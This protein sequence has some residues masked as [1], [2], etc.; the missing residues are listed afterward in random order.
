MRVVALLLTFVLAGCQGAVRD[1]RSSDDGSAIVVVRGSSC[2]LVGNK[3]ISL[4]ARATAVA[5]AGGSLV[6][7]HSDGSVTVVDLASEEVRFRGN[8]SAHRISAVAVTRDGR[9]VAAC[10]DKD[11]VVAAKEPKTLATSWA[12]QQLVFSPDGATLFGATDLMLMRFELANGRATRL[13]KMEP[14]GPV[15][16]SRDGAR[17]LVVR[18]G[19]AVV[20]SWD[21]ASGELRETR[22][23]GR[24]DHFLALSP[25]ASRV[26]AQASDGDLR[27]IDLASGEVVKEIPDFTL[28]RASEG[29]Q[30]SSAAFSADEG[31]LVIGTR[32]G[33]LVIVPL[34]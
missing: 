28:T 3:T 26:L 9:A 12:W 20:E 14:V 18:E 21:V 25:S 27:V 24:R 19:R 17:L 16:L 13:G 8:V 23:I 2:E 4:P 11:L 7:G 22:S 33:R 1:V 10:G 5:I 31:T 32:D 29:E 15:T 34:G 6:A 30:P